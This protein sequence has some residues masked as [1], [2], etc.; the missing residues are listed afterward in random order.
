MIATLRRAITDDDVVLAPL[1]IGRHVDH[2]IARHAAENLRAGRLLYYPELPYRQL[3]PDGV[4][5]AVEGLCPL[6]YSLRRDEIVTWTTSIR[7]YVSQMQM[8]EHAAGPMSALIRKYAAEPLALYHNRE[9]A[10]S[11]LTRYRIFG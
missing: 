11:D 7:F 8:L 10:A 9:H 1:A 6:P 5:R 2:V 4:D 3:F